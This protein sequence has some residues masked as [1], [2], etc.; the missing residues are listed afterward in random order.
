MNL[1]RE[2]GRNFL[3]LSKFIL[4]V[5]FVAV[6]STILCVGWFTQPDRFARGYQPQ[7]PIPYSHKLHAGIMRMPCFYCHSGALKSRQAGIPPV[8]KCLNC[9]KVTKTDSQFI[10]KI[11][12][13]YASGTPMEWRRI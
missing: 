7:Q 10:K 3:N 9:H 4:P 2:S 8:E 5:G 1:W 13:V 6:L 12:A 11:A